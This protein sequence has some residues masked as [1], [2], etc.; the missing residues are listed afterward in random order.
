FHVIHSPRIPRLRRAER[1]PSRLRSGWFHFTISEQKEEVYRLSFCRIE[2]I[3]R[4]PAAESAAGH[5]DAR[6]QLR[7]QV[8]RLNSTRMGKSSRRPA[9]MV[10][11]STTLDRGEN[12]AKLP[13]GPI[14]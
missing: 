9:I 3:K 10:T 6:G 5:E 14:S 4:R 8:R 13:T 11:D 2:Q 7:L 12:S 1:C